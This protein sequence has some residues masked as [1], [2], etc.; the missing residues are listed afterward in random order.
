[1]AN[2]HEFRPDRTGTGFF[3]H[4]YLTAKQRRSLLKWTLYGAVL[5]V[6]SL[7]Q[8]VILSR[9]RLL[10]ATT[11]LVP[12]AIFLIC[13]MEGAHTGSVF[14]LVSSLFY[15]FSGTVPG[16]YAMAMITALAVLL[17][18]FRQAYLQMGFA[19]CLLCTAVCMVL[20]ELGI[21]TVGLFLELTIPE[22]IIGFAITAGTSLLAVPILYP[23]LHLIKSLGGDTW[24]E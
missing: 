19:A 3:S 13:L 22:R 16:T 12:C 23:V 20:Y 10:G 21:F 15:L 14:A 8:D 18:V 5:L 17:C 6:V 4:L 11:E 9:F 2:K 7:V 1:M 24:K